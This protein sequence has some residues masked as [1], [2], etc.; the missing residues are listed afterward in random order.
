MKSW[1]WGLQDGI[2]TLVRRGRETRPPPSPRHE[3]SEGLMWCWS[4]GIFTLP[5]PTTVSIWRNDTPLAFRGCPLP[6]CYAGDTLHLR[7]T[8][9]KTASQPPAWSV[10]LQPQSGAHAAESRAVS[11]SCTLF[12]S[13]CGPQRNPNQPNMIPQ[14]VMPTK[15]LF[16]PGRSDK[17]SLVWIVGEVQNGCLENVILLLNEC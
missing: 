16:L 8:F 7:W 11:L 13:G 10:L 4:L 1:G 9:V 17:P 5:K 3:R 2:S 15:W 6:C 12:F 14:T